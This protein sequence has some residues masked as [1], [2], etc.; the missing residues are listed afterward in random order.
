MKTQVCITVDIEFDING[1]FG[2]P[3]RRQ[4]RG[5]EVVRCMVGGADEG[6]GFVLRTLEAYGLRGVFFVEALNVCHFG[7]APMGEIARQ[8]HAQGHDVGLH[9]HPAW[10]YFLNPD[11]RGRLASDPPNDWLARRPPGEIEM[12]IER[13]L[14][15]FERWGLPAPI[16][17]RAGSLTVDRSIYAVMRD[18]GLPLSSHLGMG[19]YRPEE[20]ELHLNCGRHR[21]DGVVEVP[22]TS[23]RDV[24]LG[25]Y[26]HWKILTIQ[27]VSASEAQ[28]VLRTAAAAGV[29]PVVILTHAHEY[30]R[31]IGEHPRRVMVN[32]LSRQRL[33]ALCRFLTSNPD[34]FEVTTFRAQCEAWTRAADTANPVLT[35]PPWYVLRRL[36]ENR[37]SERGVW[38]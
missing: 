20:P 23:Y 35:V 6:L 37:L 17:V 22:V 13:G 36:V 27:G 16:A 21:I 7:D 12:L 5:S 31:H 19:L 3:D 29:N 32:R 18:L 33:E 25:G 9:L 14:A 4:P 2:D 24:H 34:R 10:A 8:I 38:G 11:W 1:A 15:A 28:S 30:V 26:A